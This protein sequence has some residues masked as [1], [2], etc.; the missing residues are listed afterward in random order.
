[1]SEVARLAA[2]CFLGFITGILLGVDIVPKLLA[3]MEPESTEYIFDDME[4]TYIDGSKELIQDI[5]EVEVGDKFV[6]MFDE[7]NNIKVIIPNGEVLHIK[8]IRKDIE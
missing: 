1:M 8:S 4:I 5:A 2:W 6:L 3:T 7:K